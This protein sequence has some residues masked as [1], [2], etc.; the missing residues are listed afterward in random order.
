M[1]E[2]TVS[3]LPAKLKDVIFPHRQGH[4]AHIGA[5]SAD[6]RGR[7]DPG[8]RGARKHDA[9]VFDDS[10][11][12]GGRFP[13]PTPPTGAGAGRGGALFSRRPFKLTASGQ[14]LFASNRLGSPCRGRARERGSGRN[15]QPDERSTRSRVPNLV[16]SA[17]RLGGGR[18]ACLGGAGARQQ[19]VDG[20]VTPN[21]GRGAA[22]RR[23]LVLGGIFYF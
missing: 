2:L 21:S 22:G 20:V 6:R 7:R 19:C 16:E 23:W 18:W 15:A 10:A 9:S 17:I 3:D 4:V 12:G 13:R 11:E 8:P 14:G 5:G 1:S